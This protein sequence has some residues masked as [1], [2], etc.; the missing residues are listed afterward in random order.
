MKTKLVLFIILLFVIGCTS[1]EKKG[2]QPDDGAIVIDVNSA[3]KSEPRNFEDMIESIE[4]I[5]LET[6]EASV[7][8][9][10]QKCFVT[11][12][13]LFVMDVYQSSLG[14]ILFDRNGKFIKRFQRGNG[15][16]ELPFYTDVFYADG[17]WYVLGGNK[18]AKYTDN[19]KFV[20]CK[21]FD[22]M[23]DEIQ[24]VGNRFLSVQSQSPDNKF[25]IIELDS[26]LTK[27]NEL[28]LDLMPFPFFEGLSCYD[29]ENCLIFKMTDNNIYSYDN[30]NGFEIKYRLE[31]PDF[32]Y[33]IS[34]DKYE[35]QRDAFSKMVND[36]DRSKYFFYE[37]NVN[38]E[39]YLIFD[40]LSNDTSVDILYNKNTG[41][42]C[43][44]NIN[45]ETDYLLWEMR[46]AYISGQK[47][48][49]CGIILPEDI[50]D[51]WTNN[52]NNLLS[53]KDIEILKN[54]KPDDNP[55][56]VIY[57]LKDNL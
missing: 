56:I 11:D 30:S 24:K 49:L 18:L 12:K 15:P 2:A 35:H 48:T 51:C 29:G 27:I 17:Y 3:L 26:N 52:P 40:L 33:K 13:Y 25:K 4:F 10:A 6:T 41:T 19:G 16:E 36:M 32:E 43:V 46:E 21:I 42:A 54:A 31:Y 53:A 57:K 22:D 45:K 7:I 1:T 38:C 50:E 14:L 37:N 20:D 23:S 8:E 55:I 39:D 44:L 28:C 47:N 34:Y 9:Y 5:P